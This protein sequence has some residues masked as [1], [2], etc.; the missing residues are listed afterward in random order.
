MSAEKIF[1]I[2]SKEETSEDFMHD[3]EGR[4]KIEKSDPILAEIKKIM[5]QVEGFRSGLSTLPT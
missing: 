4:N 5:A 3:M 2:E 1:S